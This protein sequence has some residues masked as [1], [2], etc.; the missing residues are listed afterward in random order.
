MQDL[1]EPRQ[2]G[3]ENSKP[4]RIR[5]GRRAASWISR[6]PSWTPVPVL[7]LILVGMGVYSLAANTWS[8]AESVLLAALLGTLVTAAIAGW[9]ISLEKLQR[10]AAAKELHY[11]TIFE[12]SLE[13]I[14]QTSPGG[15]WLSANPA[16]ARMLGYASPQDLLEAGLDLNREFYVDPGRRA[17]FRRLMEEHDLVQDFESQVRARDGRLMWISES[18]RAVRDTSGDLRCFEGRTMDISARK[19]AE[20]ALHT[21]YERQ[22]GWI[23]ELETAHA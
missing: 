12:E 4:Q 20:A 10:D 6:F 22:A 19:E 13:G 17:E 3:V 5:V 7:I 2:A 11:Q 9:L 16:L 18:A 1:G 8:G 21:E 15:R 14:Y 23:R